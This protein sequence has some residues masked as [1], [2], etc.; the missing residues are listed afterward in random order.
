MWNTKVLSFI[1]VRVHPIINVTRSSQEMFPKRKEDF[2]NKK[3]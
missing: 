2:N 3:N 1:Q